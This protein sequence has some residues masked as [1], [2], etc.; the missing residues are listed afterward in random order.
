MSEVRA[1]LYDFQANSRI[2]LALTLQVARPISVLFRVGALLSI[3]VVATS[4]NETAKPSQAALECS[5]VPGIDAL[6]A[7]NIC[8]EFTAAFV[9]KYPNLELLNEQTG[10]NLIAVTITKASPRVIGME[11]KWTDNAGQVTFGVPLQMSFFDRNSDPEMRKRFYAEFLRQN[12][13]PF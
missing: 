1:I 7:D 10:Q 3:G 6:L 2:F 13:V 9:E 5:H 8:K 4:G 11:V 12:P